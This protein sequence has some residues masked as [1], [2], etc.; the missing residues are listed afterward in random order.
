M[1]GKGLSR[2]QLLRRLENAES[3]LNAIQEGQADALLKSGETL[4]V[5]LES[6][7]REQAHIKRVL[8]TIRAVNKLI[9]GEKDPRALA[10]GICAILTE[11]LSYHTTWIAL[12][13]RR[14]A[15]EYTASSGFDGNFCQME[16]ALCSGNFPLCMRMVLDSREPVF[17]QSPPEECPGCP[18]AKRYDGGGGFTGLLY[19]GDHVFGVLSASVPGDFAGSSEE[20][21]LFRELT[22]DISLG[23]HRLSVEEESKAREGEKA[24]ILD[25]ISD[26]MLTLDGGLEITYFNR[27]AENILGIPAGEVVGRRADGVFP[28]GIDSIFGEKYLQAVNTGE[29]VRFETWFPTEPFENWYDIRLYPQPDGSVSVYFTVTTERKMAEAALEEAERKYRL[30]VENSQSIIYTVLPDGVIDFVSPSW[31]T[32]LG[33]TPEEVQG[34]LFSDF[35][36][37][38]DLQFCQQGLVN[39]ESQKTALPAAEFRVLH[40][41]GSTR[42][43]RSVVTPVYDGGGKL[44]QFVGNALDVTRAKSREER[45]RLLGQMLD[46]APASITI[47]N[48]KGEF[49]FG[50]RE[51]VKLHGYQSEEEFKKVNLN[52]LDV[53][54]SAELIEK[55]VKE[56]L[57]KGEANFESRHF[58]KDGTVFPLAIMA[59]KIEW[60]GQRAILSIASDITERK[61]LEEHRREQQA[62]L[63]AIYR[64]APILMMVVDGERRVQ[65]VNGFATQ[66]AERTEEEMHGLRGGEA[67][68]CVHALDDPRGCGFG[69]ACEDCV[70]KNTVLDTLESG[71]THL[72][73]E[74]LYSM[75]HNGVERNLN[76][77]VSTT[78]L[79]VGD[80]SMALVTMMD[81]TDRTEAENALQESEERFRALVENSPY[82]IMLLQEGRY[83]YCNPA[84]AELLGYPHPS[85]VIGTDPLEAFTGEYGTLVRNRMANTEQGSS[86][87]PVELKFTRPDGT[88]RWSYSTSVSVMMNGRPAAIVVG[89]DITEKKKIERENRR[90]EER[91]QQ[92]QRLE[93]V[94]RLAGGVAHDLNNLLTP[95]LGYGGMLMASQALP[96]DELEQVAQIVSAGER[97]RDLVHQLLAF[98]R[99]QTLEFGRLDLNWLLEEFGTL[100]RRTIT[101]DIEIEYRLSEEPQYTLGDKGQ[102]EQILMNLAVNA[103]DA[104]PEGGRLTISTR[105]VMVCGRTSTEPEEMAEGEYCRLQV[106]DTGRGMSRDVADQVFEPFFTTKSATEGTGLGLATVYG[107]VKQHNGYIWVH[108]EEGKGTVFSVYLPAAGAGS[109]LSADGSSP[110]SAPGG[111][112]VILLVEDDEQV[113][114]LTEE[115]LTG[116]GYRVIP[117]SSGAEAVTAAKNAGKIDLLLTDVVMPGMNGRE[118]FS[119]LEAE[120][121]GLKV[122]Y[123]SGYNDN[124][125]A[126]RGIIE[127]GVNF[128]QKPFSVEAMALK[129]R[130]VLDT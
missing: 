118:L 120:M 111:A 3:A 103:Q 44:I 37:E 94:G 129:V 79:S 45:I 27:A 91:F 57:E 80:K 90:L 123:M 117:A 75:E 78:P 49:L 47:H 73:V 71:K 29:P 43:F 13:N 20:T 19:K 48:T 105:S 8:H 5:Q 81:I 16:E 58:R 126:S 39:T 14:G 99:K 12:L 30:L 113:R 56:I 74:A 18:L 31:E 101:E 98:S 1:E 115:I 68:R 107:I 7:R 114:N 100:L 127:N 122:L 6:A 106:A 84:G 52:D 41:D 72:Q 24:R 15:V 38:G 89:Q 10:D 83:I 92:F 125:I 128:I 82:G 86:N 33:H 17:I 63:T 69:G 2:E 21:G 62:L 102:I 110:G 96:G 66:F 54:E 119:I 9:A 60:M 97:A 4:I 67:L 51:T 65:Q 26:A 121:P 95:V 85:M 34:R 25:S 87:K 40:A 70:I 104:M 23:F 53:P 108:S 116:K 42:W 50:N 112:E 124:V 93:S 77:L 61:R 35:V 109:V 130:R 46:S 36:H 22:E 59:K 28:A 64:N 88:E 32:H 11:N 55:R 76:L